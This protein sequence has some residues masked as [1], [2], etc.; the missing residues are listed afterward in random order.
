MYNIFTHDFVHFEFFFADV[1]SLITNCVLISKA[2]LRPIFIPKNVV[3]SLF[4]V[5]QQ[6][7][8]VRVANVLHCCSFLSLSIGYTYTKCRKYANAFDISKDLLSHSTAVLDGCDVDT[9]ILFIKQS[10]GNRTWQSSIESNNNLLT[11]CF[12][13][14]ASEYGNIKRWTKLTIFFW[15]HYC[16]MTMVL[17]KMKSVQWYYYSNKTKTVWIFI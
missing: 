16:Y 7:K 10:E 4:R 14:V 3:R 13:H 12:D 6:M 5:W 2:Q 17:W 9:N 15:I 11:T 1:L 8:R